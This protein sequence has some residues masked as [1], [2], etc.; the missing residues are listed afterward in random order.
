MHI[1]QLFLFLVF[2]LATSAETDAG[3]SEVFL[4][5]KSYFNRKKRSIDFYGQMHF[6][7]LFLFLAFV[8][9]T[10][11]IYIDVEADDSDEVVF[12]KRDRTGGIRRPEGRFFRNFHKAR[13][14]PPWNL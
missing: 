10:S 7:Q 12:V 5:K 11:A 9:A 4:P 13:D 14:Y 1:L 2:V 8:L 6:L 3:S